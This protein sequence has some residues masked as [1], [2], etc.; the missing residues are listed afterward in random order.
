[1]QELPATFLNDGLARLQQGDLDHGRDVLRTAA[2][3][4]ELRDAVDRALEL[5]DRPPG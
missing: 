1:V 2:C 4:P 3:F 5:M